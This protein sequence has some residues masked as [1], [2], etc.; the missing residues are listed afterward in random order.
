MSDIPAP[1]KDQNYLHESEAAVNVPAK[2]A[3][4][5]AV[6]MFIALFVL[7]VVFGVD[8]VGAFK[9]AA[10]VSVLSGVGFLL[11]RLWHW[12]NLTQMIEPIIGQDLDGDGYLGTP[13]EQPEKD[14]RV[15]HEYRDKS[16]RHTETKYVRYPNEKRMYTLADAIVN[17][18]IP[19]SVKAMCEKK[20]KFNLKILTVGEY[21]A[22]LDKGLKDGSIALRDPEDS[23]AG[24]YWTDEG[25]EM[26]R[27]FL[28]SSTPPSGN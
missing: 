18:E 1:V 17:K 12:Y 22:I 10:A 8:P 21:D 27:E 15:I 23:G 14:V 28:L 2:Q 16:G 7:A 20:N 25:V 9:G 3:G 6:G 26:L 24:C 13:P 11:W 19:F 4:M 5:V